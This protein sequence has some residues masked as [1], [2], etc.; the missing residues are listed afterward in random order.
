M[1]R[2][3][4]DD[5]VG[6]A[7]EEDTTAGSEVALITTT[8][9]PLTAGFP[10]PFVP[11]IPL[12][13]AVNSWNL[14]AGGPDE[15][16]DKLAE[17]VVLPPRKTLVVVAGCTATTLSVDR[18]AAFPPRT[19]TG[20]AGVDVIFLGPLPPPPLP[21]AAGVYVREFFKAGAG[22]ITA[23]E[24]SFFSAFTG[25]DDAKDE[26][27]GASPTLLNNGFGTSFILSL[28]LLWEVVPVTDV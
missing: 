13:G 19:S 23:A 21:D 18:P 20:R 25:F 8:G 22:V 14:P 9:G 10:V 16:V 3:A 27:F 12:F 4:V 6:T 15:E 17:G 5:R 1:I 2:E 28:I 11:P 26:E 7:W 24:N